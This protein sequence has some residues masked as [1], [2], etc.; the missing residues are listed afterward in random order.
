MDNNRRQF[1]KQ[2]TTLTAGLAALGGPAILQ[3]AQ[4]PGEKLVVGVMGLGRGLDHVKALLQIPNAEIAYLCDVDDER[5]E[6]AA[7]SAFASAEKKPR[8]VKDFRMRS[9]TSGATVSRNRPAR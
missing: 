3:S 9:I 7:K 8:V 4:S 1:L 2:S 6:R 5:L